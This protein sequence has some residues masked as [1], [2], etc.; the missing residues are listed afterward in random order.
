[1]YTTDNHDV[2]NSYLLQ[3]GAIPTSEDFFPS[4]SSLSIHIYS[5]NCT[6]Q[7]L[8]LQDCQ[9]DK[10]NSCTSQNEVGVICQGSLKNQQF[11]PLQYQETCD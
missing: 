4:D 7:E 6:G 3:I 9:S 5:P 10:L 2:E 11:E 8:R 1:M